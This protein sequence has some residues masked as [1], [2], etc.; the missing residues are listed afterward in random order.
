MSNGQGNQSL[1]AADVE[2]TGTIKSS[3]GI[4][5]EGKLEGELVCSAD[6]SIGKNA[7]IKGNITANSVVIE[8]SI[9]GNINAKDKIDM[10]ATAKVHGDI[11]A[12]RLAVEDGVTFIG[13]SEVNPSGSAGVAAAPAAPKPDVGGSDSRPDTTGGIF[14]R[15]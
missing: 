6:A 12:K 4:R 15:R 5:I 10:K 8:G 2:I 14:G 7:V 13:H 3:S 1:L 9:Q 11:K